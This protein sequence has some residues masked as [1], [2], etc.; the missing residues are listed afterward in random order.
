MAVWNQG[1]EVGPRKP[2]TKK[3]VTRVRTALTKRGEK[4]LRDLTIFNVAIDVMLTASDLL[5]LRVSDV[6]KP[7]GSI[8][9]VIT[10][11][12]GRSQQ[13]IRCTLSERSRQCLTLWIEKTGKRPRDFLFT[14]RIGKQ[15]NP[16]S[17][18]QLSRMVK[19]WVAMVDI[20]P[21]DYGTESLRRTRAT[22]IAQESGNF[23]ALAAL[24]GHTKVVSTVKYIIDN[25]VAGD[26]IE[27]SRKY[28]M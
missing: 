2:L 24:L 22:Y 21:T 26:P 23:A 6:R 13:K 18:R 17:P 25:N 27:I 19:L 9:D 4:G 28:E 16:L 5:A 11:T 8:K 12:L 1:V 7:D 3:E 10:A 15:K 14:G 20:D